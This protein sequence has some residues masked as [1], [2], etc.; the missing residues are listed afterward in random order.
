MVSWTIVLQKYTV[1]YKSMVF[2]A[3]A[4]L[5]QANYLYL[6]KSSRLIWTLVANS[7][8]HSKHSFWLMKSRECVVPFRLSPWNYFTKQTMT[9][10]QSWLESTTTTPLAKWMNEVP[11]ITHQSD[12]DCGTRPTQHVFIY[13]CFFLYR[14]FSCFDS[15]CTVH[16]DW[17]TAYPEAK[18]SVP[19]ASHKLG[20]WFFSTG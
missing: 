6:R 15:W 10:T 12:H 17:S 14:I 3:G 8:R 9:Q 19:G 16:S 13:H 1:A 18:A 4:G 20:E 5:I 2:L 11:K 7:L